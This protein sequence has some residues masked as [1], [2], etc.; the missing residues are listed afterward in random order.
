MYPGGKNSCFQKIINLIPPHRVYIELFLG[1]GAVMKNKRAAE[2]N[3]GVEVDRDVLEDTIVSIANCDDG[4]GQHQEGRCRPVAPDVAMSADIAKNGGAGA[5]SGLTLPPGGTYYLNGD[6]LDFLEVYRFT[7][8][9]FIYCDPPYIME[10][11]S[12]QRPLYKHEFA[13]VAEHVQLLSALLTLPCM[14]M[15]SG[16]RHELYSDMLADWNTYTFDAQTRGGKPAQEWLW[17]NYPQPLKLHDY[18]YLGDNFRERERI[19]RKAARWVNRFESLPL[20]ERQAIVKE[21]DK[22]GVI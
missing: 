8:D 14:V 13:T 7:G 22:A 21:L 18:R 15:I 16:Y 20:L 12:S 19:K 10:T 9:E 5:A 3:I 1:S 2:L 11:R 17:M 6:A 4:R